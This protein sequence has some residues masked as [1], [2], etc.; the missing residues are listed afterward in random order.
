[1]AL[2]FKIWSTTAGKAGISLIALVATV[3]IL[4]Q[5][6]QVHI[7]PAPTCPTCPDSVA[8]CPP[9]P[10]GPDHIL[11]FN[12]AS[13]RKGISLVKQTGGVYELRTTTR[14]NLD[15]IPV[16]SYSKTITTAAGTDT[17]VPALGR[18]SIVVT[19]KGYRRLRN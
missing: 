4:V 10:R 5:Q 2:D 16:G 1:M 3:S 13:E 12:D 17:L 18:D 19:I 11:E 8:I 15:I 14:I 6:G 9:A 7:G